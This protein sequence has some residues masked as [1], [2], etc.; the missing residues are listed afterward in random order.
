M[1]WQ[2]EVFARHPSFLLDS[3]TQVH[4]G[5]REQV[6]EKYR[7][8]NGVDPGSITLGD[9]GYAAEAI[10]SYEV[11]RS[12]K[13]QS[14][15]PRATRF[16]MSLPSAVAVCTQHV[17]ASD[18]SSV[19]SLYEAAIA[20]EIQRML[21]HIPAHELSIQWDICQEVLAIEGAWSVYYED[22]VAGAIDRLIRL[23]AFVPEPCEVGYHFCYGDPG[24]KHIKEPEN[25]KVCVTLANELCAGSDRAIGWVHMP[26]PKSRAD[27]HYFSPLGRLVLPVETELYLGLIHIT[28]GVEGARTRMEAASAYVGKFGV[29]TE[30]G[31]GRRPVST[32]PDL[33]RL[34]ASIAEL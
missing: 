32:I 28:D 31:F 4:F 22:P 7:L 10:R 14:V 21:A 23:A 34:H 26:V 12:L 20:N 3:Q 25:L 16:Q 29:A 33:L 18:Q 19:E 8:V 30:C 2:R 9:L 13:A 1:M 5:G 15:I 24:H 27:S 17:A 11:F 6:F